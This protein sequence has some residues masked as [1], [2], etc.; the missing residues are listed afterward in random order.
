MTR[1]E[2]DEVFYRSYKKAMHDLHFLPRLGTMTVM[3]VGA[4]EED[5]LYFLHYSWASA[6]AGLKMMGIIENVVQG[7]SFLGQDP[8]K[9]EEPF[10]FVDGEMK[11]DARADRG[12][13][14]N[15]LRYRREFA[16][17]HRP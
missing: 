12:A 16:E 5:E 15:Y 7:A 14:Q 2:R 10:H 4:S 3:A 9:M 6:I 13:K 11:T 8:R 17:E 1:A